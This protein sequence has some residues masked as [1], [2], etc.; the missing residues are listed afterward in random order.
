MEIGTRQSSILSCHDNSLPTTHQLHAATPPLLDLLLHCIERSL[1][2]TVQAKPSHALI[3]QSLNVN[4]P[5]CVLLPVENCQLKLAHALI[6]TSKLQGHVFTRT[7]KSNQAKHTCTD[8]KLCF[9]KRKSARLCWWI[10]VLSTFLQVQSYASIAPSTY[11]AIASLA[12]I[13]E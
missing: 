12:G 13:T 3:A 6:A 5:C 8:C 10:R 1:E 4:L 2:S 7:V 11:S 9:G